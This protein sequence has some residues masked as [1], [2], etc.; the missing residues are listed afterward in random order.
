MM[1]QTGLAFLTPPQVQ[2]QGPLPQIAQAL[3]AGGLAAGRVAATKQAA[4]E[5]KREQDIILRG[6][7]VTAATAERGQDV[8]RRIAEGSLTGAMERLREEIKAGKEINDASIEAAAEIAIG[9]WLNKTGL[10]IA[11][12]DAVKQNLIL[13]LQSNKEINAASIT[14]RMEVAK[15]QIQKQAEIAKDQLSSDLM[16][17]AA[18]IVAA[19]L[20]SEVFGTEDEFPSPEE[21]SIR[22]VEAYNDLARARGLEILTTPRA[23]AEAAAELEQA[24]NYLKILKGAAAGVKEDIK[25]LKDMKPGDRA[26]WDS[27]VEDLRETGDIPAA[28]VVPETVVVPGVTKE[29]AAVIPTDT[30]IPRIGE[31]VTEQGAGLGTEDVDLEQLAA[32]KALTF[33]STKEELASTL[34]ERF[35]MNDTYWRVVFDPTKRHLIIAADAKYGTEVVSAQYRRFR[36]AGGAGAPTDRGQEVVQ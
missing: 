16:T 7:D 11:D 8:D 35:E 32:M 31:V 4:A 9:E 29:G 13:T 30:S 3:G 5:K 26:Y 21:V 17:N 23:T 1:F 27:V 28:A 22:V 15:A 36:Q 25:V 12:R 10:S 34:P 19:E 6:Q 20:E 2:G 18:A 33:N 24:N 14:G